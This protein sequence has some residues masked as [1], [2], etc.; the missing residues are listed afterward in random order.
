VTRPLC[1]RYYPIATPGAWDFLPAGRFSSGSAGS[2][3]DSVASGSGH[4]TAGAGG[5]G[6][7]LVVLSASATGAIDYDGREWTTTDDAGATHHWK[8]NSQVGGERGVG[9]CGRR[10]S[11][12]GSGFG[13]AP[14][15]SA[16]RGEK[17]RV[18]HHNTASPSR[19]A[20]GDDN[21]RGV[22]VLT[23]RRDRGSP[24]ARLCVAPFAV[25]P[26]L[27]FVVC[28]VCVRS[29]SRSRRSACS[30]T[31]SCRAARARRATSTR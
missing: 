11:G 5:G 14:I 4:A 13:P 21:R 9:G 8:Q 17:R 2:D 12:S 31:S 3:D 19:G 16:S 22:S 29:C 1:C 26:W 27:W 25:A 24:R 20:R 15:T 10:P 30:S 23:S 18:S 7:A 6:S 28:V